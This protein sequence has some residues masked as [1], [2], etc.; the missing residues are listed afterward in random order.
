MRPAPSGGGASAAGA[1][2]PGAGPAVL[3]P[4]ADSETH[5]A[6]SRPAVQAEDHQG[7]LPPVR[8]TGKEEVVVVVEEK[9][10]ERR[11]MG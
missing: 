2:D 11:A 6:Q 5:G 4:H 10:E 8:R 9:E 1:A 7:L 3:P